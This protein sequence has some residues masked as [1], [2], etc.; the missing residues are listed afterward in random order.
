[1]IR[2][3]PLAALLLLAAPAVAG[4]TVAMTPAL[5]PA[6]MQALIPA[7]SP[8]CSIRKRWCVIEGRAGV[9]ATIAFADDEH[10]ENVAVGN[11]D[12]LADHSQ[13]AC[14]PAVRQA[15]GEPRA[16]TNMTDGD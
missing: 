13:Q 7:L 14:Q 16:R 6:L 4:A 12:D 2:L 8:G 10:I 11:S 3:L 9:Q 5:I 1:M 15:A